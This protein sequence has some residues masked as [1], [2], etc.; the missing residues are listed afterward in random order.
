MRPCSRERSIIKLTN[1]DLQQQVR[2]AEMDWQTSLAQLANQRAS[3]AT[4]RVSLESA[5]IDNESAYELVAADLAMYQELAKSGIAAEMD[6]KRKSAA[7]N[8]A[9]NRLE[10]SKKQLASAIETAASSRLMKPR[11]ISGRPSSID[12]RASSSDLNVKS[13]MSGQLQ[14]IEVAVG[15]QVGPGANLARVS[16]PQR[17]KAEI[18]ISET[19]TRDLAFGQLADIDTRSGHVKGRV[20]RIDPASRGGTVGVDV[21][22]EGALPPGARPD[23]GV[24]GTIEL[25]RLPNVLFVE[26]PA[27]GQENSTISLFK[28]LPTNEAVRTPVKV[29]RRAVSVHRSRRR[30]ARR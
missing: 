20:V 7:V 26:S 15:Q 22:L 11:R 25:E 19:Q 5:V 18:R 6:I 4:S 27:F 30:P 3:Q 16:D 9:K 2:N 1:P 12:W 13:T 23:L 28:V 29:G 24:D 14:Q 21:K 17:L 10:L 8:Q